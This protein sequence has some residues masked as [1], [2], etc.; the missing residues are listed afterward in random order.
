MQVRTFALRFGALPLRHTSG[1]AKSFDRIVVL[2]VL[3]QQT[4]LVLEPKYSKTD[5]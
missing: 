1:V 4:A 5:Y 2:E 3:M